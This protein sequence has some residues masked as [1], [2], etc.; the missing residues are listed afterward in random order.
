MSYGSE[1][2][3]V[4]TG[5]DAD[6]SHRRKLPPVNGEAGEGFELWDGQANINEIHAQWRGLDIRWI[7]VRSTGNV[8][9]DTRSARPQLIAVLE[10]VGC[11]PQVTS[12]RKHI[13]KGN[14]SRH[15]SVV[16]PGDAVWLCSEGVA[17]FSCVVIGFEF[18][19]LTNMANISCVPGDLF[20]TQLMFVS[21]ELLTISELIAFE[22]LRERETDSRYADALTSTLLLALF[23]RGHTQADELRKGGLSPCQLRHVTEYLKDHLREGAS[24]KVLSGLSQHHFARSFKVSTGMAPLEWLR[25]ERVRRLQVRLSDGNVPL[26]QIAA[27]LGF[28][29]QAHMTRVFRDMVGETPGAWRRCHVENL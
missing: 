21:Q 3:D 10:N 26:V 17:Y 18:A 13:S 11:D 22:C 23:R 16:A 8:K 28:A 5:R 9:I 2:I 19:K 25:V 7:G 14:V 4:L 29:D 6:R 1:A 12:T 15:L 27:E 20:R 24:L